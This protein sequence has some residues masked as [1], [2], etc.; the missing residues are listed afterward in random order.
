MLRSEVSQDHLLLIEMHQAFN[1]GI[2]S[3]EYY[4]HAPGLALHE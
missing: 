1:A 2:E 3:E 4:Y